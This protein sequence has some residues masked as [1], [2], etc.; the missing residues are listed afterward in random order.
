MNEAGMSA[1]DVL[2]A[3]TRNSAEACGIEQEVGTLEPGKIADLLVVDGDPLK[4]LRI[5][6]DRKKIRKVIKSGI[7]VVER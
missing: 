5:L 7:V 1:M 2:T 3:A 6:Q 4:D